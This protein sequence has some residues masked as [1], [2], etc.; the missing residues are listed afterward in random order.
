A[1]NTIKGVKRQYK[2]W[3]RIFADNTPGKGLIFRIYKELLQLNNNKITN[4]PVRK[5]AKDLKGPFP[6]EAIQMANKYMKGHLTS[7]VISKM[8]IKSTMRGPSLPQWEEHVTLD[9]RVMRYR[10]KGTFVHYWCECKLA[11]PLWKTVWGLLK[12]LKIKQRYD[13]AISLLGILTEENKNTNSKRYIY[14]HAHWGII[15]NRQ[16]IKTAYVSMS[17]IAKL[18]KQPKCPSVDEWIKKISVYIYNG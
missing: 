11:Q 6:K 2:E 8:Q 18:W 1:K 17:G 4:N 16:C 12:K 15:Y 13:P 10:E 14:S 9:L 3:E 7:L 5:Q